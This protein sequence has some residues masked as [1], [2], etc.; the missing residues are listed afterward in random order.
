MNDDY[1]LS[2]YL[3]HRMFDNMAYRGFGISAQSK[4][5]EGVAYNIGKNGESLQE[6]LRGESIRYDD[7]Y[8]LPKE[9]LL[10]KYIAISGY[11]GRFNIKIMNTILNEDASEYFKEQLKYLE[12]NDF[13][14]INNETGIVEITKTGFKYYG[15]ILAMFY[16]PLIK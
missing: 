11:S 7:I 1:G 6:C 5:T 10:A 9:E 4:N 8:R 3:R 16:P 14:R 12:N 2:S 15:A 13:I